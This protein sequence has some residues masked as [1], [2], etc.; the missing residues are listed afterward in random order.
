[1]LVSRIPHLRV[2]VAVSAAAI[3]GFA[4]I[5]GYVLLLAAVVWMIIH[6]L[7]CRHPSALGV[8]KI[9]VI[10]KVYT[11]AIA[12]NSRMPFRYGWNPLDS[13]HAGPVA[14]LKSHIAV[15]LSKVDLS[16]VL[17]AIIMPIAV[18]VVHRDWPS[19]MHNRPHDAMGERGTA[20]D[21]AKQVA[22]VPL[23]AKGALTATTSVPLSASKRVATE[24]LGAS[25]VPVE[26]ACF[27]LSSHQLAKIRN[28]GHWIFSHVVSPYVR[29]QGRTLLKQRFRPV[30]HN[31]I[32]LCS[33]AGGR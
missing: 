23:G 20:K 2:V 15:V 27:R 9:S 21:G 8:L 10:P 29:G 26:K 33:Q 1:M 5:S 14:R 28:L 31:R 6:A 24:V 12:A 4:I 22:V 7:L 25:F 13:V 3:I 11:A 17:N 30:F 18:Y 19:S 16:Q 32:A